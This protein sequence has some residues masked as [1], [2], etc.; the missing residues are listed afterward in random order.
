[1]KY[2]KNNI[3]SINNFSWSTK[4]KIANIIKRTN[5]CLEREVQRKYEVWQKIGKVWR[6]RMR[7]LKKKSE[8]TVSNRKFIQHQEN[9]NLQQKWNKKL[10]LLVMFSFDFFFSTIDFFFGLLLLS[11][12]HL[13]LISTEPSFQIFLNSFSKMKQNWG[14]LRC[15]YGNMT[16]LVE[17]KS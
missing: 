14:Y 3:D 12:L 5:Q 9:C 4:T 16:N 2:K 6:E 13:V 1:M 17:E 8:K 10:D 11:F 15:I 7:N